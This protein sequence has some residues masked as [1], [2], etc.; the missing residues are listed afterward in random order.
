M[1]LHW[2]GRQLPER[3]TTGERLEGRQNNAPALF[4]CYFTFREK[5]SLSQ[6]VEW[7]QHGG[8]GGGMSGPMDIAVLP[9]L[10][11][12]KLKFIFIH[13]KKKGKQNKCISHR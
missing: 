11:K 1:L 5:S 4:Y 9:V 6:L 2:K 13:K 8:G 12:M 3:Q 10:I 7:L